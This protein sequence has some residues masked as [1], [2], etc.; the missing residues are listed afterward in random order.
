MFPCMSGIRNSLAINDL[1]NAK[2]IPDLGPGPRNFRLNRSDVEYLCLNSPAI[3]KTPP[4]TQH[5]ILSLAFLWHDYLDES[6]RLAQRIENA[7]GYFAHAI[8]HR[9][10]PDYSNSKY[11]F[12]QVGKHP[13]FEI[14]SQRVEAF[15]K[16]QGGSSL[17]PSLLV[18][19]QW[20]PLAFV[21]VCEAL[22]SREAADSDVASAK[23]IQA[24]EIISLVEQA[25]CGQVTFPHWWETL[26]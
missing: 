17:K 26:A 19:G 6:H 25:T 3:L 23:A 5:L 15:F 21:D 24:I 13:A 10:E 14:L 2:S 8:M 1:F 4:N 7:D 11:W 9:R 18:G 16:G 12:H 22:E 20:D